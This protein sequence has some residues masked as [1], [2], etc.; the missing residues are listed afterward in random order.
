MRGGHWG[1]AVGV[2]LPPR[3]SGRPTQRRLR[4]GFAE[5]FHQYDALLFPVTTISAHG[6]QPGQFTLDGRTLGAF[7][8]SSMTV[9]FNLTGHPALPMRFGTSS[10]GI[11]IGVQLV[12]NPYAKP[13]TL[14]LASAPGW[15]P[16]GHRI[17]SE[18]DYGRGQEKTWVYGALRVRDGQEVTMGGLSSARPPS[19]A[20]PS[21]DDPSSNKPPARQHPNSTPEPA[22]GY[23]AAPPHQFPAAPPVLRRTEQGRLPRRTARPGLHESRRRRCHRLRVSQCTRQTRRLRRRPPE[24]LRW[25]TGVVARRGH[26]VTFAFFSRGP[27][28]WRRD[29]VGRHMGEDFAAPA[30]APVVAVR[31]GT[32]AWSNGKGGAYGQWIGAEC[33]QRSR[34]HLLPP[35]TAA[36]G[37]LS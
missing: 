7:H 18:V 27:Y 26:K 2:A 29:G 28:S 6:H 5:H 11:P 9:P 1:G 32:V 17:K 8:V 37:R 30:G 12:A 14:H 31:N 23:G 34:L 19:S 20:S 25:Q 3:D 4:V 35:V 36:G 33:Q 15:S 10:D 13:T 22:P 24:R 16:D 21:P